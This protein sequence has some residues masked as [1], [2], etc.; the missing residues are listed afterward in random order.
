M[1]KFMVVYW[2]YEV[3][4]YQPIVTNVRFYDSLAQARFMIQV[5]NDCGD[6]A[7]LYMLHGDGPDGYYVYGNE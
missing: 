5:V 4:G 2:Y 6:Y 7:Q 3:N 1:K